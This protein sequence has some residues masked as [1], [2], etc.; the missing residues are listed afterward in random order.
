MTPARTTSPSQLIGRGF[1]FLAGL[2]RARLLGLMMVVAVAVICFTPGMS[3]ISPIDR[4]EARFAQASKQMVASGDYVTPRFQQ[5]LRAK[6]P[7]G[8]YW[9]QSASARIFGDQHIAS[10]RVPSVIGGVLMVV[11]TTLFA[12]QLLPPRAAVFAGLFMATSLVMVMESHLATTDAMLAAMVTL[13]QITLWKIRQLDS[14]GHYVSGKYAAL[15]WAAMAAAILIKGPIAP[16]VAIM[17]IA[18]VVVASGQ[19]RDGGWRWVLALKPMLGVI[20]LTALVLP[21][22][23]L[24]TSATD[25]A[26]LNIAING[27]FVSKL[28]SG[29]E[30]HGAPPLTYLGLIIITFWPASLFLARAVKAVAPRW[31]DGDILFLLGWLLPFWVILEMTPTKLPHYNLPLFTALVILAMMGIDESL[32]AAKSRLP[33]PP[34]PEQPLA[35]ARRLLK[36]VSITRGIVLAWEWGFMALGPVLGMVV[37]YLATFGQGSRM[38]AAVA[39]GLACGVSAAAFWWQRRGKTMA[40]VAMI[41]SAMMFYVVLMGSV[42]PSLEG[43]RLAPRI[44]DAIATITPSPQLITAAGYHEPSLVFELGTDILLFSPDEAAFFMAEAED[45]LALVEQRSA[46]EFRN[47]ARELGLKLELITSLKGHNYSRGQDVEILF[48]RRPRE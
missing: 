39:F 27:D 12:R 6:K 10:Y 8:I 42:L 47:T 26:F 48:Y 28:K 24:V 17:T 34:S 2:D 9:M 20:I 37:I 19:W 40:L 22:V 38:A 4:D 1:R 30:S 43:F 25:G 33:K 13:Q 3:S 16:V 21:W 29:Q 32:P 44:K 31:R 18:L 45:G 36:S 5:D 14:G 41:T 35:R 23:V 46:S 7:I 11:L 15:F